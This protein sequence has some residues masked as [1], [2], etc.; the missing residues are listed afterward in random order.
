[1]FIIYLT[2]APLCAARVTGSSQE[3]YWLLVAVLYTVPSVFPWLK[4]IHPSV[5]RIGGE[6]LRRHCGLFL[7]R[8]GRNFEA[9][10]A[11]SEPRGL[12]QS[13]RRASRPL[14]DPV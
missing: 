7:A 11:F 1:M 9:W 4:V 14:S 5:H 13:R 8:N 3:H 6:E 2:P 10:F 12:R